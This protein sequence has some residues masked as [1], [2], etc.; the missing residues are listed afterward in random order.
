LENEA[1]QATVERVKLATYWTLPMLVV[2]DIVGNKTDSLNEL[3]E[4]VA[5]VNSS[6]FAD[7]GF[8]PLSLEINGLTAFENLKR[9]LLSDHTKNLF[10]IGTKGNGVTVE[11]PPLAWRSAKL[12]YHFQG[13]HLIDRIR[14]LIEEENG[15][16]IEE[17]FTN[18]SIRR[19][20][21][22]RLLP[23]SNDLDAKVLKPNIASQA[24]SLELAKLAINKLWPDGVPR[25]VKAKERNNEIVTW[26]KN[27]GYSSS[28]STRTIVKAVKKSTT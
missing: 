9:N 12:E 14:I 11:I 28:P 3:Y 6:S 22:M 24:P 25:T 18:V 23:I 5:K 17:C 4:A 1:L 15:D 26:C 10:V 20:D 16:S 21:V 2:W 19:D 13:E 27:N 7:L 8:A